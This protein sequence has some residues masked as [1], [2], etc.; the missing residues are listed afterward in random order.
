MDKLFSERSDE[1]SAY[2]SIHDFVENLLTFIDS[3]LADLENELVEMMGRE[4]E[5][6]SLNVKKFYCMAM[7]NIELR[8]MLSECN[9][10]IMANST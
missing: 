10:R 3:K 2:D 1:I 8:K 4:R 9:K 7:E 6:S 5:S